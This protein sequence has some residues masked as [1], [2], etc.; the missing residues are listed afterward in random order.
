MERIEQSDQDPRPAVNRLYRSSTQRQV[1]GVCGGIAEYV[2]A[3]P[4]VVRVLFIVLAVMGPGLLLYPLLWAFV[5]AQPPLMVTGHQAYPTSS[6][7]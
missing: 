2:N 1:G 4:T 5:P 3:D 7:A 6:A